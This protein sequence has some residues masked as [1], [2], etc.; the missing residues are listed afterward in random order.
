MTPNIHSDNAIYQ[1]IEILLV[2]DNP[3]DARLTIEALKEHKMSN[4][5]QIHHVTDGEKAIQFLKKSPPY[6]TVNT[7]DIV[8]LD[9]NLPKVNGDEVL[10][11]IRTTEDLKRLVV[12]ML[13]TSISQRDIINAYNLN[14]NAYISKPV[15]FEEFLT[16]IQQL[17]TFWLTVAKLPPKS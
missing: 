17:E 12:I 4:Y 8:L 10:K 3:H 9:L 2:E 16:A 14:V 7:P 1:P 5:Q 11:F 15:E 13:T 6:D